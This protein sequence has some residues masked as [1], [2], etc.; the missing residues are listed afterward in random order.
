MQPGR[1]RHPLWRADPA[2]AAP[3]HAGV[4]PGPTPGRPGPPSQQ[5]QH[6]QQ[7]QGNAPA[8]PPQQQQTPAQPA[9]LARLGPG[10]AQQPDAARLGRAGSG[11]SACLPSPTAAGRSGPPQPWQQQAP[12]PQQIQPQQQQQMMQQQQQAPHPK[13]KR[14]MA[15]VRLALLDSC[16]AAV[17]VKQQLMQD[18]KGGPNTPTLFPL[19]KL[20]DAFMSRSGRS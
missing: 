18:G 6:L 20:H 3:P 8:P 14:F 5:Q 7:R 13:M 16:A 1:K 4:R 15:R 9:I 12:P 17:L 2:P 11:G 10:P 19:E